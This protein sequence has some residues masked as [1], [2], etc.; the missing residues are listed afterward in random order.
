MRVRLSEWVAGGEIINTRRNVVYGHLLLRE[1]DRPLVLQLTGNCSPD[2]AGWHIRFEA[3]PLPREAVSDP[4]AERPGLAAQQIGPVGVMTAARRVRVA[5]CPIPELLARIQADEPPPMEWKSCLHLEWFSQN[6]RVLVELPDPIIEYVEFVEIQGMS[7]SQWAPPDLPTEDDVSAGGLSITGVRIDEDG[8]V[9]MRDELAD[10]EDDDPYGLIPPEL[11]RQFEADAA[12]AARA[13]ED[14]EGGSRMM[15]EM[16][17][18]DDLVESADG[19]PLGAVFD[20]PVKLPRPEDLDDA[21]AEGVLRGLLAQLALY[22][23][24]LD[25]CEHVTPRDAYRMLVEDL[26]SE[27]GVFPEMR[28]TGWVQHFATWES[29]PAC[30]AEIEHEYDEYAPGDKP[31]PPDAPD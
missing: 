3:R 9:V 28:A 7:S 22:G 17:R 19:E 16:E 21:R 5:D 31:P 18:M 14:D 23:I 2:L 13:L 20:W 25:M 6:G 1:R 4:P 24:A 8:H 11:R 12:E 10:Q 26:N 15:Q 27:D 29:C 30:Q